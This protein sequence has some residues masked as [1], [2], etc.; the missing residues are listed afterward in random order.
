MSLSF[1]IDT[2]ICTVQEFGRRSG[3][4]ERTIGE[5]IRDGEIPTVC[6][7]LDPDRTQGSSKYINLVLLYKICE[8]QKFD[9][10]L[11]KVS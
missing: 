2:P 8:A 1:Q 11:L 3:L 10:P 5:R 9:H 6:L 4:P 7:N